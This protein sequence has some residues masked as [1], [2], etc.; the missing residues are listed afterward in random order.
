MYVS[1]K[2]GCQIRKELKLWNFLHL[3]QKILE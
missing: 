1:T 2:K 3:V